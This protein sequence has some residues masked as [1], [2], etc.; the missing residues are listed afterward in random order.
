MAKVAIVGDGPAGLSAA[1][2]LAKNDVETV[3]FG[4]DETAMHYA[5]LHNYLGIDEIA[6]SEFQERARKQVTA[7]GAALRDAEVTAVTPKGTRFTVTSDDGT[8]TVDYVLLAGGKKATG[9]ADELGVDRGDDG[10]RVDG[11]G[12]TSIDAVYA[13]GR[14]VRPHRSQAIISAGAGAVAAVDI[15]SRERGAEFHD[16]DTPDDE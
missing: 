4:Q 2:F 3:V 10:I 8:E 15:L 7:F 14:L 5:Y 11:H 6:G 12:R 13:A 1:L 16:W 9:I